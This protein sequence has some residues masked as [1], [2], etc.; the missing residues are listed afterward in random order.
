VEDPEALAALRADA[1]VAV[2]SWDPAASRLVIASRR[3]DTPDTAFIRMGR[4]TP[5]WQ[6]EEGWYANEGDYRWT[7]P[8]ATAHLYRPEGARWFELTV[9]ISPDMLHDVGRTSVRVWVEDQRAGDADFTRQG[10]QT[11]RWELP[12]APAGRV[13]VRIQSEPYHP[14]NKDPR[15]LGI[16]VVSFGFPK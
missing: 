8:G 3:K 13:R 15:A 2:L 12:P 16:P 11:V 6:L 10:W 7:R 1:P 4:Q 9:N 5:I 14:S